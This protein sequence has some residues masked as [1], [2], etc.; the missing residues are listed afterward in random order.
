MSFD[1]SEGSPI[2]LQDGADWTANFR[3][4]FP[5]WGCKAHFFGKEILN[6]ILDQEG[7]VGIRMYYGINNLEENVL[8]LVGAKANEDDM[9]NGIIADK[10]VKCPPFCGTNNELNG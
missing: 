5:S 3:R 4:Q 9:V 10:S 6:D 1:G 8:I 2:S 7:C